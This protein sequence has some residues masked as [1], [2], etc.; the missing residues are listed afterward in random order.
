MYDENDFTSGSSLSRASTFATSPSVA[1]NDDPSGSCR[2]T[3]S[4][5][6]AD[7][8]KNCFF[9]CPNPT[10]AAANSASVTAATAHGRRTHAVIP[11]RN[12]R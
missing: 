12:T 3:S 4:S 5:G 11:F 2:S 7:C 6:R 1:R 8:G 9:T 10:T